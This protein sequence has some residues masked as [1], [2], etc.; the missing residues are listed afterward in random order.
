MWLF[1]IQSTI[2]QELLILGF[3]LIINEIVV[4]DNN[5]KQ[6][7][8]QKFGDRIMYDNRNVHN[9]SDSLF[10]TFYV[11]CALFAGQ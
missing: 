8:L 3:C 2:V 10:G 7:Q 4:V 5:I 6:S 1:E 11:S 9:R